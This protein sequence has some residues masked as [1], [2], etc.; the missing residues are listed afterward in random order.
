MITLF[1]QE[2]VWEIREYNIAQEAKQEGQEDGIR[3]F[4]T[5]LKELSLDQETVAQKLVEKLGLPP[6]IAE[7]KVSH[8]WE[9]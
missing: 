4:V 6:Q 3:A 5:T 8:Y 1:D 9:Q 7:K 2:K